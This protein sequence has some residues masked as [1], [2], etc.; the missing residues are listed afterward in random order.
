MPLLIRGDRLS[1]LHLRPATKDDLDDLTE[2]A[3]AGFPDDPEFDYRFP[4]RHEY[5]GD[6][7]KWIRKEYE[8]YLDQPEKYAVLV[9]TAPTLVDSGHCDRVIALAVWDI[10][11]CTPHRGGD[12]GIDVRRDVNREHFKEFEKSLGRAFQYYFGAY[13]ARQYHL[14]LLTTHPGFRRRG[15]GTMLCQWGMSEAA[16]RGYKATVLA[17]PMGTKLYEHLG[18]NHMGSV[19]VRVK[20]E[21]EMLSVDCLEY[22][23]PEMKNTL[24]R[25]MRRLC[26]S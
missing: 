25:V 6:N 20:E 18:Y 10:S 11:I 5:P 16:K 15:A 12:L 22:T 19:I 1:D 7:Y 13:G 17:S 3:R 9:V 8:E 21:E 23:P 2:V 14:W 26:F 4:Y 24:S